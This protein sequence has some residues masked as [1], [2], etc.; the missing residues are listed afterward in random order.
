MTPRGEAH[1]KTPPHKVE[2]KRALLTDAQDS[3]PKV[4]LTHTQ[5]ILKSLSPQLPANKLNFK[6]K[7]NTLNFVSCQILYF[8]RVWIM[9]WFLLI[10]Q[11]TRPDYSGL[12]DG[13]SC[14]LDDG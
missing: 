14:W 13:N 6:P 5:Q 2:R 7:A 12:A 1:R 4:T 3:K 11:I 10:A 9:M 8:W